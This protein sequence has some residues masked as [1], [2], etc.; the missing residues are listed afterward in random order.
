MPAPDLISLHPAGAPRPGERHRRLRLTP[1]GGESPAGLTATDEQTLGSGPDQPQI[2]DQALVSVK[3][4]EAN[5]G[6]YLRQA[7]RADPCRAAGPAGW[8]RSLFGQA[9]A[10]VTI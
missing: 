3:T 4:I 1:A 8:W 6:L 10:M 5:V 7:R 2:T 9:G